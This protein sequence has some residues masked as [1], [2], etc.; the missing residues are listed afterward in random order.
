VGS[1]LKTIGFAATVCIVCSLLLSA[2]Y[3]SLKPRQDLNKAN[4]LKVKVLQAFGQEV[5]DAKGRTVLTSDEIAQLF[6]EQVDGRVLDSQGNLV[7]DISVADLTVEQI[8][9]RDRESRLK[10]YYPY[11]IF[12]DKDS[13]QKRYAVHISGMGLWSVVKG[14]LALEDDFSTVA[15]IA[16]YNHAETPGLG[17][18][19]DKPWFTAQFPGKQMIIGG[20]VQYFRVLKP[21][22][23]MDEASVHGPSGATM[24]SKGITRFVNS[25]FAV[26]HSHF[27]GLR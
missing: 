22:E 18:E 12:T 11:Y 10:Q 3:S 20:D 27:Q 5:T 17:G 7:D 8:N 1:E 21:G 9:D 4:D 15:G 16:F 19:I 23:T 24:T 13:G 26:Y 14:Y 25:D 6:A 2:V